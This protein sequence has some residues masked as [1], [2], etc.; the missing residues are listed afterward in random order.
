MK[1]QN[2][3]VIKTYYDKL[4]K[5]QILNCSKIWKTD[6]KISPGMFYNIMPFNI[7]CKNTHRQYMHMQCNAGF[8]LNSLVKWQL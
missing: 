1:E 4:S 3:S 8:A 6:D 2:Y 5:Y 7:V